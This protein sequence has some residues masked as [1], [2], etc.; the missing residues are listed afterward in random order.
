LSH[1]ELPPKEHE[2]TFR[3]VLY[4]WLQNNRIKIKEQTFA[5]YTFLI[6]NHI[7]PQLG[8]IKVKK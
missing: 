2:A 7:L 6:E 4:L 3:E 5:K 1:N 8:Q